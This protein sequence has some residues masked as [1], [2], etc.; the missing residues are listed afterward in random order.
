M[1]KYMHAQYLHYIMHLSM[2]SPRGG[3]P[4]YVGHLTYIAFPTLG[5]LPKNLGPRVGMFAFL[6]GEM[7]TSH[8]VPCA[9]IFVS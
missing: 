4:A 7:R 2:L 1:K 9:L 5:N 6:H 8:I 3:T